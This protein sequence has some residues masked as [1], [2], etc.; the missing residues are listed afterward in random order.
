M[1]MRVIELL[2]SSADVAS[3]ATVATADRGVNEG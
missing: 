2:L 1:A 3:V